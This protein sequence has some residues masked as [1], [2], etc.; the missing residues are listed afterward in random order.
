MAVCSGS[1]GLTPGERAELLTLL[2]EDADD[3]VRERA[4]NALFSESLDAFTAILASNHPA[5]QLIRYCWRNLLDKAPIAFDL[6][7]DPRC[8]IVVLTSTVNALPTST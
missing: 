3:M 8:A 7:K 1:A 4:E 5:V 2:K 6:L